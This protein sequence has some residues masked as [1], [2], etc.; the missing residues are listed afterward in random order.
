MILS[1]HG[2]CSGTVSFPVF[3]VNWLLIELT[4][5]SLNNPDAQCYFVKSC[6]CIVLLKMY[7][8]IYMYFHF[9]IFVYF[10]NYFFISNLLLHIL[11]VFLFVRALVWYVTHVTV[12]VMH[13]RTH[14]KKYMCNIL[15]T[16][17]S[18]WFWSVFTSDLTR[19]CF[20]STDLVLFSL[21]LTACLL[22]VSEYCLGITCCWHAPVLFM[23]EF[24][25]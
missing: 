5:I 24:I 19:A 21:Q 1:L 16:I 7:F 12:H 13:V 14:H 18:F 20:L 11:F 6:V 2:I 22:Y 8:F 4:V 10:H 3:I 15:G 17:K 9:F 25:Y 23:A